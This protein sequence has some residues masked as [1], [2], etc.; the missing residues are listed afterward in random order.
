[1]RIPRVDNEMVH[2]AAARQCLLVEG[3]G[4]DVLPGDGLPI[5][6]ERR[7]VPPPL[8]IDL[9]QWMPTDDVAQYHDEEDE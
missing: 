7:G 5:A 8:C 2:S 6:A 9:E 3:N 1:M 4:P